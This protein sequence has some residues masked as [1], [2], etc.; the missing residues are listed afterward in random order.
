[1]ASTRSLAVTLFGVFELIV[2]ALGSAFV[3]LVFG[4]IAHGRLTDPNFGDSNIAGAILMYLA[5]EALPCVP[6]LVISIGLLWRKPWA[7]I[8][9]IAL[10]AILALWYWVHPLGFLGWPISWSSIY[11]VLTLVSLGLLARPG[12]A[13]EFA[14]PSVDR[15]ISPRD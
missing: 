3:A 14:R 2:G 13:A 15:A 7:R 10:F 1:M 11:A 12:V 9:N 6:L 8:A 4:W 5:F